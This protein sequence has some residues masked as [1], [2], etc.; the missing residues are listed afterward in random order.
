M[1]ETSATVQ[2]LC[3]ILN[4]IKQ[5]DKLKLVKLLFIADKY[6]LVQY[7]RTITNDDYWAMPYGPIGS[8]AKDV[9]S[10]DPDFLSDEEYKYAVEMLKPADE[11]SFVPGKKC[12]PEGLDMLSVSDIEILDL[13]VDRF[14]KMTKGDLIDYT[15]QYPEWTRYKALFEKNLTKRERIQPVELLS[16]LKDDTLAVSDEH[17]QESR[18]ILTGT[19]D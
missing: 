9:L 6:H 8:V 13:V 16:L 18:E 3:Y 5:A 7:G 4:K 14:G 1:I 10:L 12:V 19:Y 11:H 15:Q 2:A 17:I